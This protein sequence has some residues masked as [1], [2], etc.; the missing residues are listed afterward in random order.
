MIQNAK[1]VLSSF[2]DARLANKS[3]RNLMVSQSISGMM[4]LYPLDEVNMLNVSKLYSKI[5]L[6]AKRK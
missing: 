6:K 3:Q 5:M 2:L 1:H 4:L